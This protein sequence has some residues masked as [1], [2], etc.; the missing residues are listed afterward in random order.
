ML[1]ILSTKAQSTFAFYNRSAN[2]VI[3]APVFDAKGAPLAGTNYL[4][5]LYGGKPK[6]L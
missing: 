4:A 6:I 2:G 3:D 1:L 5:E